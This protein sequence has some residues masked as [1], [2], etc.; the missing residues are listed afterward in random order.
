MQCPGRF[1]LHNSFMGRWTHE[2]VS[3][4]QFVGGRVARGCCVLVKGSYLKLEASVILC[5]E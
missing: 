3:S 1:V 2:R 4:L 5:G